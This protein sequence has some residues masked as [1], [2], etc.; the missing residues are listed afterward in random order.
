V[1][2]YFGV[3]RIRAK[4]QQPQFEQK[5]AQTFSDEVPINWT[6]ESTSTGE[7]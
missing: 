5:Q 6:G 7:Y 3:K 4:H 2:G 1:S